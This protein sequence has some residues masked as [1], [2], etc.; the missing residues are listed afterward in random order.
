LLRIALI[1]EASD[2]VKERVRQSFENVND[3]NYDARL[4]AVAAGV[5]HRFVGV[6]TM[7]GAARNGHAG[8]TSASGSLNLRRRT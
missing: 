7:G 3:R 4:K 1:R 2:L 6:Y 8:A 5:H